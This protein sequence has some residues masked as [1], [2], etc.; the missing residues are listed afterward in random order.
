MPPEPSDTA[1][2]AAERAARESYGRLVAI[3]VARTR[4]IAAAEDALAEAFASALTQWPS[5]G[6]PS[7][8]E[9]W[10]LTVARRRQIDALRHERSAEVGAIQL[11]ILADEVAEEPDE[12]PDR[13]LA[14]MFACADPGIERGARAPLMLQTV[15]GL[16]GKEIA[17]AFLVPPETMNKRLVRAKARI[18]SAGLAF[19][20]PDG[21]ELTSRLDAVLEAVY[22]AYTKGWVEDGENFRSSLTDEAIWLARVAASLLPDQPE[23]RGLLALLLFIHARRDAR[24]DQRGAYVSLDEQD[25]ALW[26][27]TQIEAAEQML[28]AASASGPTGRYQIEAAIQSARVT[29]R[30]HG[31]ANGADILALYDLL[32]ALSPS[33]VVALNRAIASV[34]VSGCAAAFSALEVLAQ[35][36][37]MRDFQPYWAARGHL[38]A[39]LEMWDEAREAFVLA[40]GLSSDAAV[41]QYLQ[42]RLDLRT[43]GD[44]HRKSA[45][46]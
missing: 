45:Q 43:T 17:S 22:A 5:L 34:A 28:I 31:V 8:P 6:V 16:T 36:R 35:D 32:Y 25:T 21:E 3:L 11:M 27:K 18:Q 19:R 26:D 38:C 33:P 46:S 30:L 44:T 10:L 4:D 2:R 12:I 24:R 13:R 1:R 23:A 42:G 41:R 9:A 29:Q 20:I 14:L 39:E 40:M 7:N 37:R 15:L